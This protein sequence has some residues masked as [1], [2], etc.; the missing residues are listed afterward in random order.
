[1]VDPE[2]YLLKIKDILYKVKFESRIE[3]STESLKIQ[4][5]LEISLEIKG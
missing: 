5:C 4:I 2:N 3:N 1:M